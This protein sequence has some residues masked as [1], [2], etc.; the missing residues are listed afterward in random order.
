MLNRRLRD[1]PK[2]YVNASCVLT[3][4]IVGQHLISIARTLGINLAG[5][6]C[7]MS[8]DPVCASGQ[9]NNKSQRCIISQ[10]CTLGQL[11]MPGYMKPHLK[12]KKI[13]HLSSYISTH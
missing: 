7:A 4:K 2:I 11:F 9:Y 6:K 3:A 13:L 12:L 8:G 10:N 5:V 1:W